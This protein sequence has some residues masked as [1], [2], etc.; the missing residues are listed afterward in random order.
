ML[1]PTVNPRPSNI[2]GEGGGGQVAKCQPVGD[3]ET[4]SDRA[5]EKCETEEIRIPDV[6]RIEVGE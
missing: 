4:V 1:D 3:I 6:K 5:Q 2:G